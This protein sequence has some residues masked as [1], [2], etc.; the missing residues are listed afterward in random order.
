MAKD[1]AKAGYQ[2]KLWLHEEAKQPLPEVTAQKLVEALR[3]ILLLAGTSIA[4][5]TAHEGDHED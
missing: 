3:D 5:Q 4:E 2:M 1:D